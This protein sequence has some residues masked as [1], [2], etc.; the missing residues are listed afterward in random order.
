[1]LRQVVYAVSTLLI[2]GVTAS[3][4]LRS[5]WVGFFIIV[6]LSTSFWVFDRLR[7]RRHGEFR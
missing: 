6:V 2:V 7:D 4:A 5:E 1:V 3:F